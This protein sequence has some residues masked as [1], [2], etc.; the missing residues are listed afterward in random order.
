MTWRT[1]G[2]SY[3]QNCMSN[4]SSGVFLPVADCSDAWCI[5]R[6]QSLKELGWMEGGGG[7]AWDVSRGAPPVQLCRACS[8]CQK[9]P[10]A[11]S[12]LCGILFISINGSVLV[13]NRRWIERALRSVFH[14]SI[15]ENQMFTYHGS[16][17]SKLISGAW[18]ILLLQ[19]KKGGV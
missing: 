17:F 18:Y 7:S 14:S 13:K 12:R 6:D 9:L 16:C 1:D 11:L 15:I 19:V 3:T 10:V 5:C 2:K 4:H 8:R